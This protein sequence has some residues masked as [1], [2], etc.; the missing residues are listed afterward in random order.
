M[1]RGAGLGSARAPGWA[2][3]SSSARRPVTSAAA[4]VN[5]YSPWGSEDDLA[6]THPDE[7]NR[8]ITAGAALTVILCVATAVVAVL[9]VYWLI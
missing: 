4:K 2:S 1:A 5:R 7:A 3:A 6:M 9:A 8:A